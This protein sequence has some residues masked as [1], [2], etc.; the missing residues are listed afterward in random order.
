MAQRT[1]KVIWSQNAYDDYIRV[2]DNLLSNWSEQVTL[3]FMDIVENNF[4]L[5]S[6]HP[7]IGIAS[8]KDPTVR[9]V[10]LTKHN[11]L[12]HQVLQNRIELLSIFDTRQDPE[13]NKF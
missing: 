7:F 9:S 8:E 3:K 13:K 1:F 11:R 2:I 12:Y 4:F 10:L 6:T 5:L